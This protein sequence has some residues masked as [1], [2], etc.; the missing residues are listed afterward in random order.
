MHVVRR[1][2]ELRALTSVHSHEIVDALSSQ[3][4]SSVKELGAHLGRPAASL[5]YHVR[6]LVRAGLVVEDR[7]R[8]TARR[9][10][11]V[12]RLVAD[13]LKI[14]GRFG[15]SAWR[16][17]LQRLARL[18]LRA[19]ERDFTAAL[20]DPTVV[21]EGRRKELGM[22][23]AQ[24]RLTARDLETLNGLLEPVLDFLA[25]RKPARGELYSVT[26]IVSPARRHGD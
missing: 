19:V 26:A 3:G 13:E 22:R 14:D 18:R 4:P 9:D 24:A 8:P 2:G 6:K 15:S 5:Y 17:E 20:D 25:S 23:S 7:V 10:E 11:S 21:R 16:A 1:L 12:Y